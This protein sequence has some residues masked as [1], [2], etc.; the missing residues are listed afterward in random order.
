VRAV[1]DAED[2]E[3]AAQR[4]G[5]GFGLDPAQARALLDLQFRLVSRGRRDAVREELR[6]LPAP[7]GEPLEMAVEYI[8]RRSDTLV[9]G[10]P[11]ATEEHG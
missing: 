11:V 4:V 8:S 3:D 9:P 6:V 10:D 2:D 7:R 1:Q 5:E